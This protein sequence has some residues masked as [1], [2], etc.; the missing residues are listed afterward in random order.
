MSPRWM[1]DKIDC[2]LYRAVVHS[3]EIVM[4]AEI[5]DYFCATIPTG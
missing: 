5:L 4:I 1:Q 3:W 2:K